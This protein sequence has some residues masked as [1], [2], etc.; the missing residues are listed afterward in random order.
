MAHTLDV[1]IPHEAAFLIHANLGTVTRGAMSSRCPVFV[2]CFPQR[3]LVISLG[4]N[5]LYAKPH[6]IKG[7]AMFYTQAAIVGAGSERADGQIV[8]RGTRL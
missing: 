5:W 6:K 3:R 8:F 2:P 7:F 1:H 4:Q